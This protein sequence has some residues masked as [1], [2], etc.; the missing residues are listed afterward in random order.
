MK[1]ILY[2]IASLSIIISMAACQGN[3]K[4]ATENE[5]TDTSFTGAKNEVV[6]MTLDPGHFHA[7]LV[8][9][10]RVSQISPNAF[11]YAPEGPDVKRYLDR[12]NDFNTREENPTDWKEEVYTGDDFLNKMLEQK[13]GN[14]V[15]ISGNNA[16]KTT[17]I[18]ECVKAKLNVLADKPMII[19]PEKY[20]TLK[21]SFDIAEKNNVLLYDIMTER[22]EITNILQKDISHIPEVFGELLNGS[23]EDPS[24]I[25]SSVHHWFKYVAGNPIK[26][27]PWF[28]D[29]SQQGDAIVDV[30]THLA[31]LVQLACMPQKIINYSDIQL[32]DAQRWTTPLALNQFTRVTNIN[33]WPGY[34]ERELQNDTLHVYANGAI[35]YTIND[36]HTKVQVEWH[37]EAPEG[38]GDT[39]YSIMKGSKSNLIIRQGKE[40]D[41][42]PELYIEM[43]EEQDADAFK[44]TLQN[45]IEEKLGYD[46][47]DVIK[48]NDGLWRLEIPSHYRIGHEA[49]FT[50]V[51]EEYLQYL[52]DG[53]LPEWEKSYMI[54]KYKLTME[55]LKMARE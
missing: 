47:I 31:D 38:G 18:N 30:T 12:I 19:E 36:I 24:I 48:E 26:R 28:F 23:K 5:V 27:P 22:Y 32:L 35:N 21:T 54:V 50:Q 9:K 8:Q 29:E 40:Q 41:Y 17:Y 33:E 43:V 16:K 14:V 15:I 6:L 11:V 7:S 39:H 3:N 55:A 42:K 25:K 52:V 20:T 2:F 51:M 46:D 10:N 53:K 1:K 4:K 45:A 13:P 44:A 37:Y 49:H 34:L